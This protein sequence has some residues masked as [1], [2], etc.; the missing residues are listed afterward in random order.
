MRYTPNWLVRL[1]FA[2]AF[3]LAGLAAI[4]KLVNVAGYTVLRF[5]T[6]ARML[7][8]AAVVLLFVIAVLLRDIRHG[9]APKS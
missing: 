7:D 8:L 5:Y 3:G 6:P 1:L 9:F 4:E 2:V